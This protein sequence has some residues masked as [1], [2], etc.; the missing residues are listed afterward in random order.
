MIPRFLRTFL[1]ISAIIIVSTLY[2]LYP[3]HTSFQR[4]SSS[5]GTDKDVHTIEEDILSRDEHWD[6]GGLE[7][8][9]GAMRSSRPTTWEGQDG[10]EQQ[11]VVDAD[12]VEDERYRY[13]TAISGTISQVHGAH[14]HKPDLHALETGG[15]IMSKL[16]NATAK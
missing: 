10:G 1:I 6:K 9:Y 13:E 3:L 11:R 12:N 16:G 7:P 5:A 4:T 8:D 15:V 2:V 14:A